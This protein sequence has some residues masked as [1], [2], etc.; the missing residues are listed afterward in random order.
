MEDIENYKSWEYSPVTHKGWEFK[1][2]CTEYM[3]TVFIPF[4]FPETENLSAFFLLGFSFTF[5]TKILI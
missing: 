5:K 2:D 4:W 1:D 3:Q